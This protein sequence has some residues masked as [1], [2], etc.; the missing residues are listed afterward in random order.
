MDRPESPTPEE[1]MPRPAAIFLLVPLV[2]VIVVFAL[3]A[4][5]FASGMSGRAATGATVST[6]FAGCLDARRVVQE[7]ATEM[8]LGDLVLRAGDGDR[9][10]LTAVYPDEPESIDQIPRTLATPGQLELLAEGEV[11]LTNAGVEMAAVRLDMTMTPST[12]VRLNMDG[13]R[14][15]AKTMNANPEGR[16]KF[17]LDGVE[18]YD[19]SNHKTFGEKELEIPAVGVA[20][21]REVMALAAHRGIVIG[22][23]H[24]CE[25]RLIDAQVVKASV[26]HE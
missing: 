13:A 16:I 1:M 7:R 4:Y 26:A 9:F 5:L 18:I 25:I 11:I 23:P 24:S 6:E 8:G 15:V 21:D 3:Y 14:A 17:M 2:A 22:H 10:T 19:Q 20:N 12:L